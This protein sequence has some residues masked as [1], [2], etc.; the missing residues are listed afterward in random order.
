MSKKK[1]KKRKAGSTRPET[2]EELRG[3]IDRGETGEKVPY[4]DPA[5]S[6]LGTD[7]EAAGRPVDSKR[8]KMALEEERGTNRGRPNSGNRHITKPI[9]WIVAIAGIGAGLFLLIK[10]IAI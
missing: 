6:P 4:P 3:A 7:D 8:A 1:S 9:S 2:A 10:L 5:I